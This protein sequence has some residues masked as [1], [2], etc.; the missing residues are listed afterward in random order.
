VHE[1]IEQRIKIQVII[2]KEMDESKVYHGRAWNACA[3]VPVD[4]ASWDV[5]DA[6]PAERMKPSL[7]RHLVRSAFETGLGRTAENKVPSSVTD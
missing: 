7:P 4:M 5:L 3:G 2:S 1:N 6:V